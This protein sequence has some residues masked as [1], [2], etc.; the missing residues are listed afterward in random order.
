MAF[1]DTDLSPTRFSVT[2]TQTISV[3]IHG[4]ICSCMQRGVYACQ[5]Y[6]S[7]TRHPAQVASMMNGKREEPT[8][9]RKHKT[10]SIMPTFESMDVSLSR[11]QSFLMS[12]T[13]AYTSGD[14]HAC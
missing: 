7:H 5:S 6:S 1:S 2:R 13:S 9:N 10:V 14:T 4:V 12:C 11:A 8:A 3:H